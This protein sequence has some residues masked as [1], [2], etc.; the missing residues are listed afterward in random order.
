MPADWYPGTDAAL[1]VWHNTFATEVSNYLATFTGVLTAG[2][3]TQVGVNRDMVGMVV[4][5]ADEAKNYMT[6]MVAYKNL[7]LSG[8]G[9]EGGGDV[10]IAVPTIPDVLVPAVG[11]IHDIEGYTRA[12]VAQ[13]KAHPSY[14]PSVGAA[15]GIVS[16]IPSASTPSVVATTLTQY[17]VQ[18]AITKAGNSIIA[19]DA[20][21][22]A[23]PWA[24]LIRVGNSPYIDNRPPAVANTPEL[25]EYRVQGVENNVRVGA[26][27]GI[28]SAAATA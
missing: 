7:I 10:D 17:Q 21:R 14:N 12:L 3:V 28:V 2:I 16:T 19:I 8:E 20:K 13:I 15:M 25:R 24:E 11:A 4:N 23:E 6:E 27:S 22:G 1:V 9:L 26:V 5:A 18:L